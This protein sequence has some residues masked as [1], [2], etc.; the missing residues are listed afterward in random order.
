MVNETEKYKGYILYLPHNAYN[1][2]QPLGHALSLPATSN[3]PPCIKT[4]PTAALPEYSLRLIC[5]STSPY[6]LPHQ[7]LQTTNYQGRRNPHQHE[8]LY[9]GIINEPNAA[10]IAYGLNK[11]VNGECNVLRVILD[12][13][14]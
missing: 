10:T 6:I 13:G 8:C 2:Y 4:R 12:L 11:K 3:K 5:P 1:S 7:R 14:G 9:G